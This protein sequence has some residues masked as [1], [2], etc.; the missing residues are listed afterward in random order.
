VKFF[1]A[2]ARRVRGGSGV[3][4]I[5]LELGPEH[6]ALVQL[7]ATP[8]GPRVRAAL[9]VPYPEP[10]ERMLAGEGALRPWLRELRARHQIRG[11]RVVTALPSDETRLMVANY[12]ARSDADEPHLILDL[13]EERMPGARASSVVDF[14]PI[15]THG[16]K[17]DRSALVAVAPRQAVLRFLGVLEGAGLE[18]EA[19]EI[20]PLA[21]RRL[22]SWA[23]GGE[24]GDNVAVLQLGPRGSAIT[25]LWGR[26]LILYRE[27]D[28][29]TEL[30]VEQVRGAL[31]VSAEGARLM[32]SEY[33]VSSALSGDEV[34]RAR[35]IAATLAD[36]LKPGLG[37][38]AEEINRATVYTAS[39]TL[40]AVIDRVFLL[41]A[42]CTWPGFDHLLGSLISPPVGPLDPDG[43]LPERARPGVRLTPDCALA[44][45][46][47]LRGMR[48]D[49]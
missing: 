4:P 31:E 41:G 14:L 32:L 3:A 37:E 16:E 42:P 13:V 27:L 15:R 48:D 24:E 38:I 35:E 7:E 21:V 19:L 46:F 8:E 44:I 1:G 25:V 18:V 6:L 22:L 11:A 10:R 28:F 33:G 2:M 20:A 36:I 26:R 47:A 30:A 23:L 17:H 43:L 40:G 45:G 49:G 9:A 39:K 29:G 12:Q 34:P 5:G